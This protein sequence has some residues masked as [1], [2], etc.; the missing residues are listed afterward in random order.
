[1]A[2]TYEGWDKFFIGFGIVTI[3]SGILLIVQKDYLMG[4]SGTVVGIWLTLTNMKKIQ[5]KKSE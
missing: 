3:V 1:M 4:L 5:E 2:N